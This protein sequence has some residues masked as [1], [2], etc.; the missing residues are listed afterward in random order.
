[1]LGAFSSAAALAE[2]D[3]RE[4]LGRSRQ[5]CCLVLLLPFP[6][7]PGICAENPNRGPGR[8]GHQTSDCKRLAAVLAEPAVLA[9]LDFHACQGT[10]QLVAAVGYGWTGEV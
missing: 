3:V 1:M 9:G 5:G 7:A 6:E 8:Q 10:K 2:L 4:W